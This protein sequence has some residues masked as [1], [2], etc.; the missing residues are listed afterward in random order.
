MPISQDR[1]LAFIEEFEA[2]E[3][4]VKKLVKE[5]RQ[6][7]KYHNQE[8]FS[9]EE[10]LVTVSTLIENHS[11]P[12]FKAFYIEQAHFKKKSSYNEKK[13][14]Y[15][16]GKKQTE[17]SQNRTE[18]TYNPANTF[19]LPPTTTPSS[20]LPLSTITEAIAKAERESF[21]EKRQT[22]RGS[23][24]PPV[25]HSEAKLNSV[26]KLPVFPPSDTTPDLSEY[27]PLPP[28]FEKGIF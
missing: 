12:P 21:E 25:Q 18:A 23:L 9:G 24:Q 15:M 26:V 20:M 27:D 8:L 6:T 1:M 22:A 13:K 10:T 11:L 2:L 19:Q 14:R 7:I 3:H 17:D 5:L 4:N 28:A 16:A